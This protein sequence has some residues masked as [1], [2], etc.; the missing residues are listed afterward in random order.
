MKPEVF[1]VNLARG[2]IV[3]E[4]AL[5]EALLRGEI[6]GAALD[7]H[8]N[9]GEGHISPLAAL[10]NVI[11]TPHVGSA[12]YESQREIGSIVLD[13]IRRLAT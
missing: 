5:L 9:E 4:K 12:T 11:L 1:L 8:E 6:A 13:H 7:V 3:D 10:E 2:G